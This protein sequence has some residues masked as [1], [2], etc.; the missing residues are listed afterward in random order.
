MEGGV[1]GKPRGVYHGTVVVWSEGG[2]A[3]GIGN[4]KDGSPR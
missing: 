2:H 1:A 3:R 4:E